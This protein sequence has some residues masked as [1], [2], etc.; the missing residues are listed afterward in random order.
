MK[1][2][3]ACNAYVD[4]QAPWALRKTD[5]AR[6]RRVLATLCGCI[7]DLSVAIAPVTPGAAERLLDMLCIDPADRSFAALAH[8][9]ALAPIRVENPLPVFPRLDLPEEAAA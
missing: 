6:M 3:F 8:D 4:E 2:V 7:R 1:A 9:P 5:P